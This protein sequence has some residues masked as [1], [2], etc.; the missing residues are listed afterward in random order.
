MVPT[1]CVLRVP[2]GRL[3]IEILPQGTRSTQR[4][5]NYNSQNTAVLLIAIAIIPQ[6]FE[7]PL[8]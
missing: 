8:F 7:W 5:Y 2:C 6:L 1:L 4:E 3:F